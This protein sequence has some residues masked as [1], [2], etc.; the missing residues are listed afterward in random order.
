MASH[1][2][3]WYAFNLFNFENASQYKSLR[4]QVQFCKMDEGGELSNK[5]QKG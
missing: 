5:K 3:L 2:S 1:L 4:D